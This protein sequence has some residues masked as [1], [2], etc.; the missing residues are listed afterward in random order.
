[1][2]TFDEFIAWAKQNELLLGLIASAV[3]GAMPHDLPSW[4]EA[5]QWM[6]TWFHDSAKTF[7]NFRKGI[8]TEV[9]THKVTPST[10]TPPPTPPTEESKPQQ[11]NG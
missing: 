3:V 5:P 2:P 9:I 7:L 6:W 8:N 10:V 11:L 1:M 4:K